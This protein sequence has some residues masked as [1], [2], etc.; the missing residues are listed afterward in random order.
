MQ[1]KLDVLKPLLEVLGP[2]ALIGTNT[3]SLSITELGARLGV[4]E[5]TVGPPLLQPAA[6]DGARR[7]RARPRH[8]RRRRSR[9]RS[10]SRRASARRRSSS[11]T[12]RASRR[13]ASASSSAPR[14]CACSRWASR[15]RRTSIAGWSSA[16]ATRWARSSS[17]TWSASTCASRSSI[18]CTKEI[19]DQ[20]RPPAILR[21]MV[22][23]GK[24]G[25]KTGE[26]FYNVGRRPARREVTS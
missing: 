10:T 20:F 8:E 7:G 17:P 11:A 9:A 5:R 2:H 14:R 13:A 25:K 3:S 23:A 12:S 18:T 26:G 6:G 21:S 19:G 16:T 22:R 15:A 1:L 24:L 4:P